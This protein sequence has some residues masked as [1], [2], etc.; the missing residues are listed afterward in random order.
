MP[1]RRRRRDVGIDDLDATISE[2]VTGTTCFYSILVGGIQECAKE[3]QERAE[4]SRDAKHRRKSNL[5]LLKDVKWSISGRS[6]PAPYVKSLGKLHKKGYLN[7]ADYAH[8]H[9]PYKEE[10]FDEAAKEKLGDDIKP[11]DFQKKAIASICSQRNVCVMAGTGSGKSLSF[12]ALALRKHA[13]ILVVS[14]LQR[15]QKEHVIYASVGAIDA[16]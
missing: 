3:G 1:A 5:G 10:E 12:Q 7:K 4:D 13:I 2:G 6:S 15:L 8:L 14:P 16:V 11:R 9:R